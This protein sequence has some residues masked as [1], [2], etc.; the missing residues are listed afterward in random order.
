[1]IMDSTRVGTYLTSLILAIAVLF[2][3]NISISVENNGS[4]IEGIEVC[5]AE[6]VM[7]ILE[8]TVS[9]IPLIDLNSPSFN[10][11]NVKQDINVNTH[12]PIIGGGT[13]NVLNCV[14]RE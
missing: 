12:V 11:H 1:M 13:L 5:C 4:E 10:H 3:P 6:S 9:I 2:S 7:R 14:F 8:I